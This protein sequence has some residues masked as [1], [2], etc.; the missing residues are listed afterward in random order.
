[1]KN[2]TTPLDIVN[3]ARDWSIFYRCFKDPFRLAEV[4]GFPVRFINASVHTFKARVFHSPFQNVPIIE[5]NKNFSEISQKFLCAHEIG[6]AILHPGENTY[7]VTR[8]NKDT[9][10]EYEA[11]LFAVGFMF[12]IDSVFDKPV[13]EMS[14]Y[15]LHLIIEKNIF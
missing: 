2:E 9:D 15:D 3:T 8:K 7:D 4:L 11:N 6:H 10:V 14:S 5:I 1:M 13:C 12:P